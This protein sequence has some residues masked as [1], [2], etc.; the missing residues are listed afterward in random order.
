[1]TVTMM[2]TMIKT[3]SFIN[4]EFLELDGYLMRMFVFFFGG[5]G[6]AK[7]LAI[8]MSQLP[9]LKTENC[10]YIQ[11]VRARGKYLQQIN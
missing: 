2:T 8:K 9:Y 11:K 4:N 7:L 5:G 3:K 1:M 6:N 10:M